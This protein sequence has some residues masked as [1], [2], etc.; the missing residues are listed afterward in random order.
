MSLSLAFFAP[1]TQLS[2]RIIVVCCFDIYSCTFDHAVAFADTANKIP[3]TCQW[4]MHAPYLS[5]RDRPGHS[6]TRAL[7]LWSKEK[8]GLSRHTDLINLTPTPENNICDVA[9]TPADSSS[10]TFL[11]G[12][13]GAREI[14]VRFLYGFKI[15]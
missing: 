3:H 8:Q 15:L 2:S 7:H 4:T 14:S 1:T 13:R 6:L 5:N 10:L 11:F 9:I 12:E